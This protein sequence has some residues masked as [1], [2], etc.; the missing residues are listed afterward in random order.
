MIIALGVLVAVLV[1]LLILATGAWLYLLITRG[2]KK[3]GEN[4]A[5]ARYVAMYKSL[6]VFKSRDQY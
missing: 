6:L 4:T 1:L 5:P 2:N 3:R